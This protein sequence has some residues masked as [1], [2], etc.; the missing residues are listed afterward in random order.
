M[1][2]LPN[3]LYEISN[4]S[5]ASLSACVLVIFIQYTYTEIRDY[6]LDRPRLRAGIS[7]MILMFGL[8]V[9]SG[10]T[11]Y[12]RH[13]VDA[14]QDYRW[15]TK[16]P[17]VATPLVGTLIMVIGMCM[18][19]KVFAPDEWGDRGWIVCLII[20]AAVTAGLSFW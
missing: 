14:Q 16:L 6:G 13:L 9:R 4:W 12:V 11:G 3:E 1:S 19:I 18:M 2:P 20:S 10:Y 7:I 17:W 8:V 15:V 5:L